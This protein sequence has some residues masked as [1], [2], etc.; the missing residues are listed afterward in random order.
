MIG[1]HFDA[2]WVEWLDEHP[3]VE[4]FAAALWEL[5]AQVFAPVTAAVIAVIEWQ[6]R[7]AR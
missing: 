1:E 7:R 4:R 2:V 5:L 6:E 3:E